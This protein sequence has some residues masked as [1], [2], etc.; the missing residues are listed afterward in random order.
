MS[1]HRSSGETSPG[2]A[3]LA[4]SRC[5]CAAAPAEAARRGLLSFVNHRHAECW[6]Y[7]DKRNG[8]RRRLDGLPFLIGNERPKAEAETKGD[9]WHWPIGLD[10]IV[11]H[12][13]RDG[14][15]SEGSP[16][17]LAGFHFADIEGRLEEIGVIVMLGSAARIPAEALEMFRR[18]RLR[19][20]EHE[21]ASGRDA[22][23]RWADQLAPFADEVQILSL[24][25]LIR[26]DGEPV[27]DLNDVTRI[28]PDDFE[29]HRDLWNITDL[30]S[31][32]PLI[33][34]VLPHP[35]LPL[36]TAGIL[37]ER[38]RGRDAE[39][40]DEAK[41]GEEKRKENN[42]EGTNAEHGARIDL[43]QLLA[44]TI[45]TARKQQRWRMWTLAMRIHALED[46]HSATL[47]ELRRNAGREWHRRA[48]PNIDPDQTEEDSL[49]KL[50]DR[51]SRV[52]TTGNP[53]LA[54]L[55]ILHAEPEISHPRLAER[56][57]LERLARLCRIMG[58][59]LGTFGL[60]SRQ[61]NEA[62][63]KSKDHTE[64]GA[65]YLR[66]LTVL[67]FIEVVQCFSAG[68]RKSNRYRYLRQ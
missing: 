39:E 38:R 32:G 57:G 5:V 15:I 44:D 55:A 16:D 61:A 34:A 17:G 47:P 14:I 37:T 6:R 8:S 49:A 29:E 45:P 35:T 31:R 10:D 68:K 46:E 52:K 4:Q 36:D 21:D 42:S 40:A 58:T 18:R 30:N 64:P 48:S 9:R 27:N 13:R 43:D 3:R 65:S 1:R 12:D 66:T 22:A 63:G 28:H 33:R 26:D 19:I 50:E 41:M 60:S 25:G 59:A 2:I 53:F 7:G 54:A 24:H 62:I 11:T 67:G 51:I 23:Q 20:M 56:P